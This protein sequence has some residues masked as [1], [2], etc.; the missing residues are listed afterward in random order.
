MVV[1]REKNKNYI[2]VRNADWYNMNKERILARQAGYREKNKTSISAQG[3]VHY[4]NNRE[5]IR[6]TQAAWYEKNKE[7]KSATSA[8]WYKENKECIARQ[9]RERLQA[10]RNRAYDMYGLPM[11]GHEHGV[12]SCPG[13]GADLVMF[14]TISHIDGTGKQH[15]LV[16]KN[17]TKILKDALDHY[18]PARFAAECFNCNCAAQ[19]NGSICPHKLSQSKK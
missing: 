19:R 2:A 11:E 3:A 17:N 9:S 5:C 4:Q 12:C 7:R 15:R 14:G 18:D 10:L 8:A 13:C 1:Y 6:A 16:A